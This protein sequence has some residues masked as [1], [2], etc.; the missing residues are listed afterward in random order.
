MEI[1][2]FKRHQRDNIYHYYK[3]FGGPGK[4][5]DGYQEVLNFLNP[6]PIIA[7]E[8]NYVSDPSGLTGTWCQYEVGL[9]ISKQEYDAAYQ[10]AT[11]GEFSIR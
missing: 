9:R 7:M 6:E 8:H 4:T 11:E 3:V 1:A 2:Y 5:R 10:L